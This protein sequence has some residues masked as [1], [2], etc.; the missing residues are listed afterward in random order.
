MR[1]TLAALDSAGIR[2]FGIGETLD[3]ARK[4]AIF[5]VRGTRLAF[6]GY[7]SVTDDTNG[8]TPAQPAP[9]NWWPIW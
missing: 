9:R 2:H 8:A 6:L 1:D 7:E 5:D 3:Q 4:P